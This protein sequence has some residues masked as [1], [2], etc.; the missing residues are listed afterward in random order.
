MEEFNNGSNRGNDFSSRPTSTQNPKG[1]AP[2]FNQQGS[3]VPRT[4][5]QRPLNSNTPRTVNAAGQNNF[6]K[7]NFGQTQQS[8]NFGKSP[9]NQFKPSQ[10]GGSNQFASRQN[11]SSGNFGASRSQFSNAGTRP[12][13][14]KTSRPQGQGLNINKV[15]PRDRSEV[16]A[17]QG[18]PN[19]NQGYPN[20]GGAQ[21][22]RPVSQSPG[23][24][25]NSARTPNSQS[26][27]S[28]AASV[29]G[30]QQGVN[31]NTSN[32]GDPKRPVNNSQYGNKSA[33]ERLNRSMQ[34]L[35]Y[36]SGGV[37]SNTGFNQGQQYDFNQSQQPSNVRKKVGGVVLD[38]DTIKDVS[39]Q[40]VETRGKR[41]SAVILI[42][43]LLLI[44]SCAYLAI[45]VLQYVRFKRAPTCFY[46]INSDVDA[47]WFVEGSEQTKLIVPE[48]LQANTKYLV[49]SYLI[50]D[51]LEE[52]KVT[53]TV[54]I[55]CKGQEIDFAG[56][57]GTDDKL[58]R[59]AYND[60]VYEYAGTIVGG[61]KIYLFGGIDFAGAPNYI[62]AKNVK[63]DITADI[64]LVN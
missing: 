36:T 42:L 24:Q 2:S 11:S 7:S 26:P 27:V 17:P 59:T 15:Y 20:G 60:K 62:N 45:T 1:N 14:I 61:G 64:S 47:K 5:G 41:N 56:L 48:D 43:S 30:A 4:Q 29:K 10:Q 50:I 3:Q 55:T 54:R 28:Q 13:V 35:A 52:V 46:H 9:Q 33:E 38:M 21:G 40:G 51:S 32:Y 49:E 12:Q 37:G 22:Q 18:R 39:Q 19:V 53:I 31:R 6:G 23:V 8:G 58:G 16:S 44:V 63:I 25:P 34:N 57:T